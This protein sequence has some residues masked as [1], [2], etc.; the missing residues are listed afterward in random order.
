MHYCFQIKDP[1][2]ILIYHSLKN[3]FFDSLSRMVL[4]HSIREAGSATHAFPSRAAK[5]R[6]RSQFERCK[7]KDDRSRA[8]NKES[9]N[10]SN[11]DELSDDDCSHAW[12]KGCKSWCYTCE[13]QTCEARGVKGE[14]TF[15][16]SSQS[17]LTFSSLAFCKLI[18]SSVLNDRF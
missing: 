10:N 1:L 13:V 2:Q 6:G 5:R 16:R 7:N 11:N 15:S 4:G 14:M 12:R 18:D 9:A 17:W 8:H 3:W